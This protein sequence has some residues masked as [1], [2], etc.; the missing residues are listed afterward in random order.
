MH[1]TRF[2]E[3]PYELSVPE[4]MTLASTYHV[5]R[6]FDCDE[7]EVISIILGDISSNLHIIKALSL[8]IYSLLSSPHNN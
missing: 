1:G 4:C 3:H 5:T 2:D 6:A 7:R 8:M